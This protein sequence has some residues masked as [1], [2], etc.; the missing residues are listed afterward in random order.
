MTAA[1]VLAL[2]AIGLVVAGI[3]AWNV[4]GDLR[5]RRRDEGG[6]EPESPWQRWL[7]GPRD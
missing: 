6:S 5:L 1:Q 7:R 4:W 3:V 2:A